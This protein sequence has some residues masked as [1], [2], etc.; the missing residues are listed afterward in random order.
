MVACQQVAA[1]PGNSS[2]DVRERLLVGDLKQHVVEG[3]SLSLPSLQVRDDLGRLGLG[4]SD[5]VEHDEREAD[6][7]G[8]SD[9]RKD[10]VRAVVGEV[11]LDDEE[12][13]QLER[14]DEEHRQ[15]D[16]DDPQAAEGHRSCAGPGLPSPGSIGSCSSAFL[17]HLP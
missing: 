5:E 9:R 2:E 6:D 10:D 1:V 8:D 12:A 3:V 15:D 7:G 11:L 4:A 14:D 13:D 16:A 17:A